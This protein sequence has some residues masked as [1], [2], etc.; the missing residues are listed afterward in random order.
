MNCYCFH[1]MCRGFCNFCPTYC[2][3]LVRLYNRHLSLRNNTEVPAV[4]CHRGWCVSGLRFRSCDVLGAFH[5]AGQNSLGKQNRSLCCTTMQHGSGS[6]RHVPSN[7]VATGNMSSASRIEPCGCVMKQSVPFC[8][9]L[10]VSE[11]EGVGTGGLGIRHKG[12]LMGEKRPVGSW[13]GERPVGT[14]WGDGRR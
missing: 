1:L 9:R 7:Q 2:Q 11:E 10:Q 13:W 6:S 3:D 8:R 14:Q 4:I 12:A 5:S